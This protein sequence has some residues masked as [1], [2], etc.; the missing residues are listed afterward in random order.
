MQRIQ[1]YPSVTL[2]NILNTEAQSKGVSVSTYVTD[3]LEEYYGLKKNTVSVT[4]LTAT[5][6]NEVQNYISTLPPNVPFDLNTASKTFQDID[7]TCGKKPQTLRASIGRAF[8]KKLGKAP[9]ANVKKYVD[10]NGKNILS[11]NNALMYIVF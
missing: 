6:L 9:F 5:V 8:G 1:F 3:L 4:Q 11:A 10:K 2:A 7:M